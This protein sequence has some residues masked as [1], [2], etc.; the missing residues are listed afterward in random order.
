MKRII[1][2]SVIFVYL[3][4]FN[5][6]LSLSLI[7]GVVPIHQPPKD[8]SMNRA[9]TRCTQGHHDLVTCSFLT[10]GA[11][12]ESLMTWPEGDW[13]RREGEGRRV[14]GRQ[15]GASREQRKQ[16]HQKREKYTRSTHQAGL[17]PGR[18]T[19]LSFAAARPPQPQASGVTNATAPA[20]CIVLPAGAAQQGMRAALQS[21]LGN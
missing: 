17:E 12:R 20:V 6:R 14:D 13:R 11:G 15:G 5:Y 10:P 4:V 8:F 19:D 9:K 21:V 2:H 1:L 18:C 7:S 16:R 3:D